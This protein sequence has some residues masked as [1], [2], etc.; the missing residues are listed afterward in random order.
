MHRVIMEPPNG[1]EID[2]INRNE[3]DNRKENLRKASH[4]ENLMN[5]RPNRG[6]SSMFKGVTLYKKTLKWASKIAL[7]G[8]FIFLGYHKNEEDAARAYDKKAK[9]LFGE[10]AYI[11]FTEKVG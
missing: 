9:E 3:I 1:V 5:R 8:K 7:N 2:H 4:R 6:S 10:F 11:N